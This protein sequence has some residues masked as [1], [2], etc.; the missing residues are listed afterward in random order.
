MA[1]ELKFVDSDNIDGYLMDPPAAHQEFKSMMVG[2]NNYRISQA[3]H[4][5]PVI[6]KDLINSL[7]KNASINNQGS[8]GAST[9]ESIEVME[10]MCY[11]GNYASTIKKL[12]PPYWRFLVHSFVSFIYGRKG[13]SDEISKIV[14][15]SI[16]ALAMDWDYNFSK[17]PDTLDMKALGPN[18]FGLMKQSRKS[19]KVACQGLKE[20]FKVVRFAEIEDTPAVGSINVEVVEEH[21]A[22]KPKFQFAIDEIELSNDEE[23]QEDQENDLTEKDELQGSLPKQFLSLLNL[24]LKVI[25][26]TYPTLY[27]QRSEKEEIQGRECLSQAQFKSNTSI[28]P[29]SMAQ[30]IEITFTETSPMIQEIPSLFL[31]LIPMDQDFQS[32]IVEEEVIPSQGAQA[33]G[34]SF[35]TP[36]LDISKG[37]INLP[38][39]EF[40]DVVQL[41]NRVFDLEQNSAEKRIGNWKAGHSNQRA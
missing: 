7:W 28:E 34:S 11:E 41:Q 30:N 16:V 22:P 40:I 17:T 9:V 10:K 27:S 24:Y 38:K 18:T 21:M 32:L 1:E 29:G 19:A 20:L 12:L 2:L 33:S 25:Q 15:S 35:E 6:H 4:A 36:E 8:N 31:E 26:K 3:L 37:K 5:N 14:T 13:G 39:Y 23:D